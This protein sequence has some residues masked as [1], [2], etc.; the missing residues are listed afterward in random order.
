MYAKSI[1]VKPFES[2]IGT[3]GT[4][5]AYQISSYDYS[6]NTALVD[7]PKFKSVVIEDETVDNKTTEYKSNYACDF[8]FNFNYDLTEL[9]YKTDNAGLG[10]SF[11]IALKNGMMYMNEDDNFLFYS[12][13]D[14]NNEQ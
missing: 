1:E 6:G 12:D 14:T 10:C 8:I 5:A 4:T 11:G 9:E 2:I 7:I 3:T 13:K